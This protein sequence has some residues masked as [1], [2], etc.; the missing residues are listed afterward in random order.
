MKEVLAT[1]KAQRAFEA[2][3]NADVEAAQDKYKA[4]TFANRARVVAARDHQTRGDVH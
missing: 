1:T 4:E 2:K 3:S